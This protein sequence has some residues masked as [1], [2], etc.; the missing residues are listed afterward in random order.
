MKTL[1]ILGAG[2]VGQTLGY[3]WSQSQILTVQALANRTVQS[4]QQAQTFIG[5]GQCFTLD[6]IAQ[7]PPADL[8]LI[9]CPDD[10][11]STYSQ[12]LANCHALADVIVF[13]CSGAL[14]ASEVLST[15]KTQGANI[16][17]IH[18]IKSFAQ[19]SLAI[20]TF[21]GTYCGMEGD[22][23][24][25]PVLAPVFEALGAKTF[26]IKAEAKTLYHAASVIA[27]NYLVALQELALQ[28]YAQAGVERSQALAILNP[29]VTTTVQGIFQL[30][31]TQ[32]L[33]GPIARGD[34]QVV[35]KQIKALED[36]S[37]NYAKLYQ[38]LGQIA[39]QLAQ[40]KGN[41]E[42]SQLKV[43]EQALGN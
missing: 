8:W 29:I 38:G 5:T 12:Y 28:T 18:P 15:A 3:L 16:A 43:L 21:A 36:W 24:A 13:H 27:C 6:Q 32:A 30:D 11:L 9:A 19:P 35:E 26:T 37:S 25:L 42:P 23:I 40:N 41:L 31:T 4:T 14:T 34:A 33:T 39:L 17:S 10:Q 1:N 20:Q 7:M 22:D 2:R